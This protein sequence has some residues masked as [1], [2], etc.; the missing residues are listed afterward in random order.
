MI[1]MGSPYFVW[2][3]ADEII[4]S[5]YLLGAACVPHPPPLLNRLAQVRNPR[6]KDGEPG[7]E[8]LL[9]ANPG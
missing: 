6:A 8:S 9:G 4:S 7:S 3:S 5:W 1:T 2:I